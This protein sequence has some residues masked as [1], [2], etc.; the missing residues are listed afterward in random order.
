MASFPFQVFLGKGDGTFTPL[1]PNLSTSIPV[2]ALAD[3]NGDGIL[4]V[5]GGTAIL[6]GNGDGTFG[7]PI[8]LPSPPPLHIGAGVIAVADLNADKRP[9]ILLGLGESGGNLTSVS[10]MAVLLNTTRQPLPA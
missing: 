2:M 4:D 10:T 6:T 8:T 9:D 3:M 7:A 1:F 5:V